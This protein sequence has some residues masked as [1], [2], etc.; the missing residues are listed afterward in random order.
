MQ[1]SDFKF[2]IPNCRLEISD[3][4]ARG[5]HGETRDEERR[6]IGVI[7]IAVALSQFVIGGPSVRAQANP[8]RELGGWVGGVAFQPEGKL[9]ATGS[10]DG[11]VRL[12]DGATAAEIDTLRGHTDAVVGVAFS[13]DGT[14]LAS[15]SFDGTARLWHV[16]TRRPWGVLRGHRG[17]VMCLAFSNDGSLVATGGIDGTV[18]VW[19]PEVRDYHRTLAGHKSWVNCVAF[20]PGGNPLTRHDPAMSAG[21]VSR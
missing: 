2:Q 6:T 1:I 16:A 19:D 8:T 14:A 5:S 17:L 11:L 4:K 21:D 9:L 12:W 13:P 10:S 3:G 18:R 20:Q 15:A 7:A